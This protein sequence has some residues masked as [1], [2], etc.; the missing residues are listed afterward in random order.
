MSSLSI[1][2]PPAAKYP[3]IFGPKMTE[4]KEQKKGAR[5]VDRSQW[6]L[7]SFMD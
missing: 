2:R 1:L 4:K 3:A 6:L 7:S 5:D